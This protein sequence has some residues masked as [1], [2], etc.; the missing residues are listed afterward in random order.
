VPGHA[1]AELLPRDRPGGDG[2]GAVQVHVSAP[3]SLSRP[4]CAC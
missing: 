1:G 2:V 4:T 3:Y